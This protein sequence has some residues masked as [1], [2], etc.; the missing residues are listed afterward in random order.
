MGVFML[1][2]TYKYNGQV[3]HIL[4][5]TLVLLFMAIAGCATTDA[6]RTK[7]EGTASG[8]AIGA[9]AGAGVGAIIG[10]IVGDPSTGTIIGAGS[11]ALIG[12]IAG[13]SYGDSVAE[14]KAA[15][16][17][18]EKNL[19]LAI[20][21]INK[22]LKIAKDK[23]IQ[24]A[25]EILV[26][27][28]REK[29]LSSM[30][31]KKSSHKRN[32]KKQK[33]QTEQLLDNRYGIDTICDGKPRRQGAANMVGSSCNRRKSE[34]YSISAIVSRTLGTRKLFVGRVVSNWR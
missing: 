3:C 13:Y 17:Q 29:S 11:G 8:T 9:A 16:A 18:R 6:T 24:L 15:Y 23:N 14:K 26:L 4:R 30:R 12:S 20:A 32:L 25:N 22:N 19:R 34:I 27:Q 2:Q 31:I 10:A 33:A 5:I 28:K 7:A 21:D 1:F